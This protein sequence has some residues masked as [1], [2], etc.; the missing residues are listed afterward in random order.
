MKNT[1]LAETCATD[2]SPADTI[3]STVL[4]GFMIQ[5]TTRCS[6]NKLE[7]HYEERLGKMGLITSEKA[8]AAAL[9]GQE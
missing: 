9:D 8:E 1:M 7:K 6:K 3:E 2:G 5:G 4:G